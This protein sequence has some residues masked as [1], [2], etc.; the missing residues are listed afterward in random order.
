M[1]AGGPALGRHGVDRG[2]GL[3]EHRGCAQYIDRL[4]PVMPAHRLLSFT[5][6]THAWPS[7]CL[8]CQ[9][10]PAHTLCTHC[11]TRFARH[12]DRCDGCALPLPAGTRRCGACLHDPT[13][14]DLCLAALDYVWPW[15]TCIARLKFH[16]EVGLAAPLAALLTRA[17]GVAEALAQADWVLPMPLAPE[18]LAERG[19]NP[20]LLL[21]RCLVEPSRCRA[22][23]LLR[24][25][26][27]AP[28]RGLTRAQRLRNVRGAFALADAQAQAVRER[29]VVLLDDVMTTGAT[30][31]EAAHALRRAG[32]RHITAVALARTPEPH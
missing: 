25:R 10:W 14:L 27:T 20:A 4:V 17:A 31:Y 29:R 15:N 30:L 32:A 21:S 24:T 16:H 11:T 12:T 26:H 1:R 3:V 28:Q 7:Q 8:I 13:P 5:L 9:A 18:R 2:M 23:L 6:G 22:D 19:Y